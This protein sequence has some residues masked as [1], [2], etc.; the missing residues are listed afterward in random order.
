[1]TPPGDALVSDASREVCWNHVE[2]EELSTPLYIKVA[3]S[4]ASKRRWFV[5]LCFRFGLQCPLTLSLVLECRLNSLLLMLVS[6][7]A[8]Q[9]R[10]RLLSSALEQIARVEM[11]RNRQENPAACARCK[12]RTECL[13]FPRAFLCIRMFDELR[14][15]VLP[16]N[17]VIEIFV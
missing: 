15:P 1:M 14:C 4:Q 10:E 12:I 3:H 6:R 13:E 5:Y 2:V 11:K 8:G 16:T 9:T 17:G 7:P